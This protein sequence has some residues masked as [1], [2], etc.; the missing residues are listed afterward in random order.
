MP[1]CANV[2]D[3]SYADVV[4]GLEKPVEVGLTIAYA[5]PEVSGR[6]VACGTTH[7]L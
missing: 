3:A 7:S 1:R 4:Q 6:H 5:A 2:V